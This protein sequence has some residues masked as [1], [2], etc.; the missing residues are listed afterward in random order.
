MQESQT[1]SLHQRLY[2]NPV[3]FKCGKYR[4]KLII[5]GQVTCD[6]RF[7]HIEFSDGYYYNIMNFYLKRQVKSGHENSSIKYS[8]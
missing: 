8:E 3:D 4:V 2:I 5:D 1:D 6:G 7:P